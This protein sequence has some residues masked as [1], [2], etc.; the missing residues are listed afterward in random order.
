[1]IS[2]HAGTRALTVESEEEDAS[3]NPVPDLAEEQPP[4]SFE[5]D[6]EAIEV[7]LNHFR[8]RQIEHLEVLTQVEI[9][10]LRWNFIKKIENLSTITTLKELELYD[11]Q[12]S[13][14]ENLDQLVNLE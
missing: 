13:K 6:P 8:L 3:Q 5:L 12:I 11:N 7:D 9:L 10:C 2:S 4:E 1:M 14:I